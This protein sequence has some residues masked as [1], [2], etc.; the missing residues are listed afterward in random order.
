MLF[1]SHWTVWIRLFFLSS[2]PLIDP[3]IPWAV[4]FPLNLYK[5]APRRL[6]A[7]YIRSALNSPIRLPDCYYMVLVRR[8]RNE[9]QQFVTDVPRM[10]APAYKLFTWYCLLMDFF[11]QYYY[12]RLHKY[13]CFSSGWMMV[14]ISVLIS[15]CWF[16]RFQNNN[17][18]NYAIK[19]LYLLL[20][21]RG[22]S[23]LPSVC[24]RALL[25]DG[26]SGQPNHAEVLNKP[27]IQ[28]LWCRVSRII[29]INI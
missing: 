22:M 5:F 29:K 1:A 8:P 14:C 15:C 6:S 23:T 27:N 28:D 11:I 19:T 7:V 17:Y 13:T 26:W 24:I 9:L 3:C 2:R 20:A 16:F 25:D 4:S 12:V 21:R 10:G 18:Y